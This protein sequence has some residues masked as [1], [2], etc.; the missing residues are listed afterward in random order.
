MTKDKEHKYNIHGTSKQIWYV[1]LVQKFFNSKV[2]S[3]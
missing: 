2:I 1:T 3:F